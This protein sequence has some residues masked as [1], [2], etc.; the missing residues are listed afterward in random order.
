[1]TVSLTCPTIGSVST[2]ELP[3]DV[4]AALAAAAAER[5]MTADELAAEALAGQFG[6]TAVEPVDALGAFIGSVETGDPDWAS[7]DTAVLRQAA[8]SRRSA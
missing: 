1:M 5:D 6:P 8:G 7:T 4:A 2:I 3:D